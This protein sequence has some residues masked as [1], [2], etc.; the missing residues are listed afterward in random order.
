MER[1]GDVPL[2]G[3]ERNHKSKTQQKHMRKKAQNYWENKFKV[4]KPD[5]VKM[6]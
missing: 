2:G 3:G 4:T 5:A 6:A 1:D